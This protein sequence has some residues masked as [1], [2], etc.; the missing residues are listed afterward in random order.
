[1]GRAFVR[2]IGSPAVMRTAVRYGLPRRRLMQFLLKLMANLTDGRDGDL[3]DRIMAALV[4]LA[5]RR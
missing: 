3:D 2:A 4:R 1:M 5:P